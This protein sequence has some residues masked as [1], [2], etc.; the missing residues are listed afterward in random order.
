MKRKTLNSIVLLA[1]ISII[2]I[3]LVQFFFLRNSIT[4]TENQ[5][6]DVVSVALE[7][8]TFQI[9]EYNKDA[10]GQSTEFDKY[11]LVDRVSNNYYIVNVNDR[12]DHEILKFHLT[13]ELKAHYINTDFEFAIYDCDSDQMIY[14]AYICADTDSCNHEKT[15]DFPKSEKY[16]YYFAVKFPKRSQYF[17]SRLKGWYLT[18]LVIIIVVMFF[19]YSLFVITRQ[20][21]LTEIQKNFI[22]NLTHELKTPISSIGLSAKVLN[23]K[24]IVNSPERLFKYASIINE[25]NLRLSKNV[26][27]VLNLASLEKNKIQLKLKTFL[28]DEIIQ[29][30][31]SHLKQNET[32]G[33]S[34][35]EVINQVPGLSVFCDK[36]HFSNVLH[37][38][39]ENAI[40]YCT[41]KP[42]IKINVEEK[43]KLLYIQIVDNGI[44]IP[45]HARKK[46][47]QKFYRVPTGDIHD[48]K[49]FGLGLDYVKKIMKA[50]GWKIKAWRNSEE[51]STFEIIIPSKS[52]GK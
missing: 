37:N 29:D 25:Q 43:N 47:F 51:G 42:I 49:G 19:G 27:K 13:Q 16:T 10:Y 15:Y 3:F 26:E 4:Q 41:V 45:Q 32:N 7:E 18:T 52:Y 21:Q 12:I 20:R 30:A 33:T 36:L 6:H 9:L 40:K 8:V 48:V 38:I 35:I 23:D 46:I 22:N 50:H 11:T 34:S 31:V 1:T 39:L 14:G 2:G 17:N 5:F 44:G 24:G 28:L